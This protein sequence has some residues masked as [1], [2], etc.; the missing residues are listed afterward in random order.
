MMSSLPPGSVEELR[1]PFIMSQ[2]MQETLG[3]Y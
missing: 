3:S 1:L 2:M